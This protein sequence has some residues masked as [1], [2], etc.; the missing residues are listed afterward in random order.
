MKISNE[1]KIGMLVVVVLAVLAV[2]TVR[3]HDFHFR[4]RGYAV[5]AVFKD[6]DGVELNSPVKLNGME[7]GRVRDIRVIYTGQPRVEVTLW[8]EGDTRI[9]KGVTAH[10]KSMG[11]LGE[12]YIALSMSRPEEGFVPPGSVIKGVEPVSFENLLRQG[13]DIAANVKDISQRIDERL[14]VNSEAIDAVISDTRAT[15]GHMKAISANV[16]EIL[17]SNKGQ[18]N[19]TVANIEASSKNLMELSDDLKDNPW[20]LLYKPRDRKHRRHRR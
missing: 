17:A 12:K 10:I 6:I 2:I 19:K 16:D 4:Q 7:I 20:K 8:I 14:R 1:A 9:L 18:I 3:A 13:T 15:M 5:K 11:F